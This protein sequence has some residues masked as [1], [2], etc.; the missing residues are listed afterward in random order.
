[1]PTATVD[2]LN[3]LG[4]P[5]NELRYAYTIVD[6]FTRKA[7]YKTQDGWLR[8]NRAYLEQAYGHIGR[9]VLIKLH[10]AGIV[11][12]T[13]DYR[14]PTDTETGY[15]KG[16]RVNRAL[17]NYCESQVVDATS[18]QALPEDEIEAFANQEVTLAHLREL[19]IDKAG[20]CAHA[21]RRAATITLEKYY[22]DDAIANPYIEVYDARTGNSWWW[23]NEQAI[24]FCREKG[25]QLVMSKRI[26]SVAHLVNNAAQFVEDRRTYCLK[27]W[28]RTLNRMHAQVYRATRNTTNTRL[29]TE[30]TS[31]P[32]D[33]FNYVTV[34]G[35]GIYGVDIANA[36]FAILAALLRN[37]EAFAASEARFFEGLVLDE[38]T[39]SFIDAALSGSFYE[40]LVELFGVARDKA[41]TMA[42]ACIF[43]SANTR[44]EAKAKL[45]ELFP[46]LVKI[47]DDFKRAHGDKQLAILLQRI[48]AQ[49]V[50]DNVVPKLIKAN[51]WFATKHDSVLCKQHDLAQ[52]TNILHETL[53]AFGVA[54]AL[55]EENVTNL[56][57][58]R[59]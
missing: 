44:T 26:G 15:P 4:L 42:F 53:A 22:V 49:I 17:L 52:V 43:S 28:L 10:K 25:K 6:D 57:A 37:P 31:L 56:E 39:N 51:I 46:Q 50:L 29:D 16:Y 35:E 12:A 32:K 14:V 45:R 38:Q 2:A 40:R 11:E 21:A 55:R 59:V 19:T 48:E 36:Q 8:L 7:L 13:K 47:T 58:P 23:S 27:N 24:N 3:T 54:C 34:Q 1:M 30:L 9:K 41:K 18:T 33:F 20:A 5:P